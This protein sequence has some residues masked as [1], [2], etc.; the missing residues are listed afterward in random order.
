MKRIN[1]G[2]ESNKKKY[3]AHCPE[4]GYASR[5]VEEQIGASGLEAIPEFKFSPDSKKGYRERINYLGEAWKEKSS[6]IEDI[7][8]AVYHDEPEFTFD[9]K[10]STMRGFYERLGALS[11][12]ARSTR[13]RSS[14]RIQKLEKDLSRAI[15]KIKDINDNIYGKNI[16][17][18]DF[19]TKYDPDEED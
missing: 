7:I 13:I 9:H 16:E 19:D 2:G 6:Q 11:H 17:T 18:E 1:R 10:P 3:L 14:G 12:H 8:N 5:R 4:W 15:T